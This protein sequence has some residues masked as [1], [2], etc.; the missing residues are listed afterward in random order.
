MDLYKNLHLTLKREKFEGSGHKQGLQ[1]DRVHE[2][3]RTHDIVKYDTV[4]IN[5]FPAMD[6]NLIL[7]FDL[8]NVKGQG[9]QQGLQ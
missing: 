7:I 3:L 2:V 6:L 1:M 5:S 8:G 4:I 9:Q